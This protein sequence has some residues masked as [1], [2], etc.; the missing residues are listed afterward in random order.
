MTAW[1]VADSEKPEMVGKHF[2]SLMEGFWE[3][4]LKEIQ[5]GHANARLN[6]EEKQF[7]VIAPIELGRTG[8]PWSILIRVKEDAVLADAIALDKDIAAQGS[9][10]MYMQILAGPDHLRPGRGAVVVRFGQH[11]PSNQGNRGHAQGHRRR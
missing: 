4:V 7:E 3:Q 1:W 10:N 5:A 9:R 8:R 11:L 6:T 2:K